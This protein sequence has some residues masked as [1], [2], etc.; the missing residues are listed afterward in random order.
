MCWARMSTSLEAANTALPAVCR[1]REPNVP[2]PRGTAEVSE[3]TSR[4]RFIGM[5]STSL[6]TMAN[7]V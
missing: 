5:P 3:L 7:A 6:A 4:I 1:D 2:D